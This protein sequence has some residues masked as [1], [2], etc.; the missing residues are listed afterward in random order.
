MTT[1]LVRVPARATPPA[2]A[3]RFQTFY[4]RVAERLRAREV[5]AGGVLWS[6]WPLEDMLADGM[7][8]LVVAAARK[9]GVSL[10]NWKDVEE[11]LPRV[12]R[13]I[14]IGLRVGYPDADAAADAFVRGVIEPLETAIFTLGLRPGTA[15]RPESWKMLRAGNEAL[16]R[17]DVRRAHVRPVDARGA[18]WQTPV[19]QFLAEIVKT[20]REYGE[21]VQVRAAEVRSLLLVEAHGCIDD[22]MF[23]RELTS[24][25]EFATLECDAPMRDD[26]RDMLASSLVWLDARE[27]RARGLRALPMDLGLLADLRRRNADAE[28]DGM[29]VPP[30]EEG[31]DG[32]GVTWLRTQLLLRAAGRGGQELGAADFARCMRAFLAADHAALVQDLVGSLRL[33]AAD[34]RVVGAIAHEVASGMAERDD[35][36]LGPDD[37]GAVWMEFTLDAVHIDQDELRS[38][39]SSVGGS[40]LAQALSGKLEW[41]GVRAATF[42]AL[43]DRGD[44]DED[45]LTEGLLSMPPDEAIAAAPAFLE[46]YG[47][48]ARWTRRLFDG[49]VLPLTPEN[50]GA[51][52]NGLPPECAARFLDLPEVRRVR[53][54]EELGNDGEAAVMAAVAVAPAEALRAL[55]TP[56]RR[57]TLLMVVRNFL[58][59]S[60]EVSV[61]SALKSF[62][63]ALAPDVLT[64]A[65]LSFVAELHRNSD[66]DVGPWG[67]DDD[68]SDVSELLP[69]SEA[70]RAFR[71]HTAEDVL[72]WLHASGDP[73]A[74]VAE[75]QAARRTP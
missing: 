75:Y 48:D 44:M 54:A 60:G 40:G 51:Y 13:V 12:D 27:A 36:R 69:A 15:Q 1:A 5:R 2:E 34:A 55:A 16:L 7:W 74:V 64:L 68:V 71:A 19:Y 46:A 61:G 52:G 39:L 21:R 37:F 58:D 8:P 30:Y 17:E 42:V 43:V 10:D 4:E 56:E 14:E 18:L 38:E 25:A 6:E 45:A 3:S 53:L 72:R 24:L 23:V 57:R 65:A 22:P 29:F 33:T 28:D 66:E 31:V 50:V 32:Y 11:V 67:C 9:I 35:P 41:S 59:R 73:D 63:A 47:A 70:R 49:G 20:A 62:R 26:Q